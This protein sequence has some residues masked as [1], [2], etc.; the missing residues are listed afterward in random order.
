MVQPGGAIVVR[1]LAPCSLLCSD[2]EAV[3]GGPL[4]PSTGT[5]ALLQPHL[6][7]TNGGEAVVVEHYHWDDGCSGSRGPPPVGRVGRRRP[8]G[9]ARLQRG[10]A[11]YD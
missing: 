3:E 11:K 8:Q 1:G 6:D 5:R 9:G 7:R 4:Y 2:D 10:V